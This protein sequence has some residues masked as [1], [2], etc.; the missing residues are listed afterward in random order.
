MTLSS[1]LI[2]KLL[3]C[4]CFG[5]ATVLLVVV[6]H[7]LMAVERAAAGRAVGTG[8]SMRRAER[9]RRALAKPGLLAWFYPWLRLLGGLAG[10]LGLDPLRTYVRGP[11][12]RAGYPGGFTDDEVVAIGLLLSVGTVGFVGVSVVILLGPAMVWLALLGVPL[13]PLGLVSH[14]KTRTAAREAEILRA[15]P[16]VLDL[17]VLMLRSGS[18]LAVALRRVV[19]DYEEHPI[20]EELGQVLAEID[21]GAPR[22]DAM[23]RMA[24]RLKIQDLTSLADSIVQS[25]ELGWPLAQTLE[26]LAD[27]LTAERILRA[28]SKAGAAGVLVMVPSTVVLAAAVL[29]LFGPMIVRVLRHGTTIQ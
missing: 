9:R 14:L 17:L 19:E 6:A 11:Y 4:A 13:G 7:R 28:Q 10:R 27:R 12:A 20:G 23:R 22:A 2:F 8:T 1:E 3:A 15:L 18:A 25:E 16:Y 26:R 29:L 5:L 24:D 21:M